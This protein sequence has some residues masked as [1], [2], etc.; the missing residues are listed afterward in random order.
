MAGL[1]FLR[2]PNEEGQKNVGAPLMPL[3]L[4]DQGSP[5]MSVS[6]TQYFFLKQWNAGIYEPKKRMNLGPGEYLDRAVLINCLGG[7]FSPGIDMTFIVRQPGMYI[8]EWQDGA[9]PF[10][11]RPKSM[12]YG[13]T[14]ASVPFLTAGWVPLHSDPLIGLEPG[15]TSK[16]MAIPWHADYNSCAIHNTSPNPANSTTLYWSWPAQ[17]PVTVYLASE[18]QDGKLGP[19]RFSMRGKGTETDDNATAGRFQ[20]TPGGEFEGLVTKWNELGV[21]IQGSAIDG[22][23]KYSSKYFLEVESQLDPPVTPWP[24]NSDQTGS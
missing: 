22:P 5:F 4:G 19:N 12:D 2:D 9:G 11:I 10:R 20:K 24:L 14:Q 16:F 13:S 8:T 7:R 15:D 3:S 21:I 18:V 1:A 23:V 6:L 17:R